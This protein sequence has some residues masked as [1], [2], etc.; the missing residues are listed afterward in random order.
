MEAFKKSQLRLRQAQE[1]AHLGCWELDFS[2]GMALWSDE[3]C[4]IYGLP[5]EENLQSFDSWI[6]FI[7]PEDLDFV[8]K[9]IEMSRAILADSSMEHRIVLKDGTIKHIHSI[10]KF[11]FD[12]QGNPCG[13]FGTSTL[14]SE[15]IL[16]MAL[17]LNLEYLMALEI[18]FSHTCLIAV[19]S[20]CAGNKE[21]T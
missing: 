17:S 3:A 4:K 16:M 10:S 11:E 7:H 1:I 2:T 5:T 12:A 8:K 13:L 19:W 18:K 21:L 20:A 6:S 14:I 15:S 9:D